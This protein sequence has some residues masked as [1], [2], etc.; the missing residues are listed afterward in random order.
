MRVS[1]YHADE[2]QM[3]FILNFTSQ[4]LVFWATGSNERTLTSEVAEDTIL[5]YRSSLRL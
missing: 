2:E 1:Q 3:T 4:Q 5:R